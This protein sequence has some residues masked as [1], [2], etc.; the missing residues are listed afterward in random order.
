MP[1]IRDVVKLF[2]LYFIL[3]VALENVPAILLY[4]SSTTSEFTPMASRSLLNASRSEA[5][6]MAAFAPST[7]DHRSSMDFPVLSAC[8]C[9]MPKTSPTVAP[10]AIISWKDMPAYFVPLAACCS[11]LLAVVPDLD[12]SA[13]ALRSCVVAWAVGV[14]CAVMSARDAPT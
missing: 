7:L 3:S 12:S 1:V 9:S 8:A 2:Q 6:A 10:L 5:M 13:K 14:P 4:A 11:A